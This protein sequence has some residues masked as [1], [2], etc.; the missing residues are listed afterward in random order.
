[1]SMH[2][3]YEQDD[4][5][6]GWS[7]LVGALEAAGRKQ[8]TKSTLLPRNNDGRDICAWCGAKTRKSGGWHFGL[9]YRICVNCGR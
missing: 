7:G 4:D 6:D 9:D 3:L 5:E 1:M 2:Q 8:D